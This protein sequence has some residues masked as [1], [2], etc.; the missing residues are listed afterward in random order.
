MVTIN[1]C[2][3]KNIHHT[4]EE[5]KEKTDIDINVQADIEKSEIH[6]LTK[7]SSSIKDQLL[8]SATRLEC[9]RNRVRNFKS[10]HN[11]R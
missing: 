3:N 5:H 7:T 6:I 8:H 4:R 9:A 11:Y 1:H 10:T 2:Y